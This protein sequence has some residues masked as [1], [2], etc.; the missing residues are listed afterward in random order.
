M[1][2]VAEIAGTASVEATRFCLF[3][4]HGQAAPLHEPVDPP[5]DGVPLFVGLAVEARRAASLAAPP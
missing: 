1:P 4:Q 2:T 5:L 3:G